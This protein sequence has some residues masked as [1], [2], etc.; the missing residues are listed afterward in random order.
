MFPIATL[1]AAVIEPFLASAEC[2]RVDV[3]NTHSQLP[4]TTVYEAL[5]P[6]KMKA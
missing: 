1:W 2:P 3:V 4:D 6:S 5:E